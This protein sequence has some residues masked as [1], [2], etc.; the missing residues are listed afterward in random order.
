MGVNRRVNS[1]DISWFLDLHNMGQL[2]MEPKYQRR[3]VWNKKDKEFFLDTIFN[4]Y[5]CPAIYIQKNTDSSS[6]QYD[7][8]D[9]K[10][11]LSTI[12]DFFNNKIAIGTNFPDKDLQNK[13][14]K[15]IKDNEE[16]KSKFLDYVLTV[17]QLN[18]V[19]EDQWNNVFYRLNKN[20]KTLTPQELR[21]AT[22]DGWF[23]T[24]AEKEVQDE[25]WEQLKIST[26]SKARRM[27]DVEYVSILLL[28]MLE[29]QIVGYPQTTLDELYEKYNGIKASENTT[30]ESFFQ[31]IDAFSENDE[32]GKDPVN[33]LDQFIVDAN[34]IDPDSIEY[35]EA[36]LTR[37]KEYLCELL[38]CS[39][40]LQEDK[41]FGRKRTNNLFSLWSYL[42]LAP[43][44]TI[45]NPEKLDSILQEFFQKYDE[46]D[47]FIEIDRELD[48]RDHI[49]QTY[50]LNNSGASTEKTQRIERLKALISYVEMSM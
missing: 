29:E 49:V 34:G 10:Q 46:L 45:P 6:T 35:F 11:R 39:T 32:K 50:I 3:S 43:K 7:V 47:S 23:I 21:H 4:N 33:D 38:R 27:K 31:N 8:V 40:F 2:N 17:E 44:D 22:Y 20:A 16:Y 41:V 5:P 14:W 37:I 26:V 42:V 9:G 25:L 13:K 30:E 18:S 24:R 19:Q 28:T 48:E 1:Q 15:D 12:I 36:E